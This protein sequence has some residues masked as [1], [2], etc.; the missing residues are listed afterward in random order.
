MLALVIMMKI[1][2]SNRNNLMSC[3]I[4]NCNISTVVTYS[5]TCS[6]KTAFS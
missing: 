3:Y 4:S 6:N 5:F 2:R 1:S